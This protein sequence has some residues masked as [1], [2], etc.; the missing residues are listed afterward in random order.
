MIRR[1]VFVKQ[2]IPVAGNGRNDARTV[3][4]NTAL[5]GSFPRTRRLRSAAQRQTNSAFNASHDSATGIGTR[6]LRRA[7][8]TIAST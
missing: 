4:N 6:K 1:S 8:P 7:Y 2:Y 3:V 5:G